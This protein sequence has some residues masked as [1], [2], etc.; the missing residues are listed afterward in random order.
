MAADFISGWGN[1]EECLC[2]LAFEHTDQSLIVI[3]PRE[4]RFIDFNIAAASLLG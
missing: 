3:D 1:S 4:N 2:P